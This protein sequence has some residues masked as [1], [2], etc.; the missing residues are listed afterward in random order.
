MNTNSL[1]NLKPNDGT[2]KPNKRPLHEHR[3][4]KVVLAMTEDQFLKLNHDHEGSGI[5]SRNEFIIKK[6]GLI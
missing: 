2:R 4:K 5:R 3:S 1:K 6:L